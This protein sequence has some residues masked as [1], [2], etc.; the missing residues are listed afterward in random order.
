[1]SKLTAYLMTGGRLSTIQGRD[2]S[3]SL[4]FV[5][6]QHPEKKFDFCQNRKRM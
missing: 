6:S 5:H 3:F 4:L 1:M 2:I